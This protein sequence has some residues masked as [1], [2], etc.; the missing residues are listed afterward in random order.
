MQRSLW[1]RALTLLVT[2]W[3][4][5]LIVEPATVHVCPMHD[6]PGAAYLEAHGGDAGGHDDH[7]FSSPADHDSEEDAHACLC[8]GDCA[9]VAAA[10]IAERP[11][12]VVP[13]SVAAERA[14]APVELAYRPVAPDFVLPFALGPPA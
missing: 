7:G 4:V 10:T 12:G 2:V 6:G 1:S 14:P 9:P 11:S 5:V 8:L 3:L 13:A